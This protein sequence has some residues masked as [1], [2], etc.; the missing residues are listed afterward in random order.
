MKAR[1]KRFI[2]LFLSE[3]TVEKLEK[4]PSIGA[5]VQIACPRLSVDW[6]HF[7]KRPLLS[8]Y[9]CF[10]CLNEIQW[11]SVYPM[12]YYSY[13]GGRWSNYFKQQQL[14]ES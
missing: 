4:F 10:V 2:I 9:E 11:Q 12:D 8:S 1:G 3:I 5:W 13:E 6:G 14:K 7:F